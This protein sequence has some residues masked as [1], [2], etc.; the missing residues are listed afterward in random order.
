MRN[1]DKI[2][3]LAKAVEDL[4]AENRKLKRES[5][6]AACEKEIVKIGKYHIKH[7]LGED[8]ALEY[9]LYQR[10]VLDSFFGGAPRLNLEYQ[11]TFSTMEEAEKA[12]DHLLKKDVDITVG[13]D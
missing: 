12:I 7:S 9:R 3:K 11:G 10:V 8:C 4:A 6:E 13:H 2:E 5:Q 1:K